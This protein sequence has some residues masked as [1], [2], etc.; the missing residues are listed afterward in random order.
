EFVSWAGGD[1][2]VLRVWERGVGETL[3][4]GTGSCAA[5]AVARGWGLVGEHVLV[6]NPGGTLEVWLGLTADDPVE[7]AGPVRRVA[8]VEVEPASLADGGR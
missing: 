4:C 8:R 7:L 6:D 3:A 5:A 1:R 2:L